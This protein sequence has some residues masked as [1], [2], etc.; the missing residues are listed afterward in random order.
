MWKVFG[1]VLV[2]ENI[3]KKILGKIS[4]GYNVLNMDYEIV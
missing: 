1:L 3:N 4:F 2:L